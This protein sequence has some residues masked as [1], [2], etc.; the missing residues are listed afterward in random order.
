M[1]TSNSPLKPSGQSHNVL[2]DFI[3]IEM[4]DIAVEV[5]LLLYVALTNTFVTFSK[6]A[7]N[8]CF[9]LRSGICNKKNDH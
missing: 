9:V 1:H 5:W 8:S 4:C 3:T 2:L 7:I 6:K